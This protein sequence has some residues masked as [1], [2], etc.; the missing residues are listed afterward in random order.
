MEPHLRLTIHPLLT[1]PAP[2]TLQ[3]SVLWIRVL[4]KAP[5]EA[6]FLLLEKI[7]PSGALASV[8]IH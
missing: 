5:F 6:R 7:S 3:L 2:V 1:P 8:C 4:D